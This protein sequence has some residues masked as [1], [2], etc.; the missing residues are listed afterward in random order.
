MRRLPLPA[1]MRMSVT[2]LEFSLLHIPGVYD[3][4]IKRDVDA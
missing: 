3:D 4:R 1:D 2:A